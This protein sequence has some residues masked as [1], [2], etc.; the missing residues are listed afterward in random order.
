VEVLVLCLHVPDF[1][2][3]DIAIVV[4]IIHIEIDLCVLFTHILSLFIH[5]SLEFIKADAATL[6]SIPVD[7][8]KLG[9][10]Q[11]GYFDREYRH[12]ELGVSDLAV[13]VSIESTVSAREPFVSALNRD[14][15][16]HVHWLDTVISKCV[17]PRLNSLF[18]K[19]F[20]I[21]DVAP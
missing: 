4:K 17:V 14:R 11:A 13:T 3:R 18:L 16:V 2:H 8:I 6:V 15:G 12:A 19:G 20:A 10:A 21:V 7:D 9:I 5:D 1:V